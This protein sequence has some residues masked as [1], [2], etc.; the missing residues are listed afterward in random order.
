MCKLNRHHLCS[1]CQNLKRHFTY[2][3]N[4][5]ILTS[6]NI[7]VKLKKIDYLFPLR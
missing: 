2:I 7:Y 1:D 3:V 6:L 4:R 5:F